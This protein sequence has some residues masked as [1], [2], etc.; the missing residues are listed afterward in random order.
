MASGIFYNTDMAYAGKTPW[1]GLGQRI[2]NPS[3][4]T[5]TTKE[6]GLD[7][8][9]LELP[10]SVDF[11]GTSTIFEGQKALIRSDNGGQLAIVSNRYKPVQPIEIMEFQRDLVEQYGFTIETAGQLFGG[12]RVWSMAKTSEGFTLKGKDAVNL[13][14]ILV[15]SNDGSL[16]TQ[17]FFT[18]VRVVC[19]N[20]LKASLN[21][22]V[23][24]VKVRHNSVFN[25]DK[26]KQ[27]LGLLHNAWSE[28]EDIAKVLSDYKV[29]QVQAS[30][31]VFDLFKK[32]ES[33][34]FED[35]STRNQN[36]M[37]EV[38][39]CIAR[40]PGSSMESSNGTAWGLL[41]GITYYVDHQVN[42]RTQDARLD[43]AFFGKGAALKNLAYDRITDLVASNSPKPKLELVK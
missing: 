9:I 11:N 17:A 39:Q 20:T 13:Y 33:K 5:L 30:N 24:V 29:N 34:V 40:S 1:H 6:A 10:L 18:S 27:D 35:E 42:T 38:M 22:A 32:P 21:S 41:N 43:Q 16:A 31:I 8:T 12:K 28:F 25:G 15:T 3:D 7:W 37:R 2:T 4:I 14:L 19:N 26:V 23:D 36:I